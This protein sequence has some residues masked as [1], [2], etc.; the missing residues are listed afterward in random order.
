MPA[1][2]LNITARFIP[3]TYVVSFDMNGGDGEPLTPFDVTYDS[4]YG[5]LP[6]PEYTGYKFERWVDASENHKRDNH[7]ECTLDHTLIAA[8]R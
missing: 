3:N 1:G 7:C 2:D 5:A 6:I 8:G 4:T